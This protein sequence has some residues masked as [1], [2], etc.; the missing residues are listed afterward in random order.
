MSDSSISAE[1]V[2]E[3][4]GATA[5]HDGKPRVAVT[6]RE[7]DGTVLQELMDGTQIQTNPD[8]VRLTLK[9]DGSKI[10]SRPDGIVIEAKPNGSR[11]Q[12]FPDGCQIFTKSDGTVLQVNPDGTVFQTYSAD[13]DT[14]TQT[15]PDRSKV[16]IPADAMVYSEPY[17]PLQPVSSGEM[18][19]P[20]QRI[21]DALEIERLIDDMYAQK[22]NK[23]TRAPAS[24]KGGKTKSGS[25]KK[26]ASSEQKAARPADPAKSAP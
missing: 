7:D 9:P 19:T 22:S 20:R 4:P 8:G 18:D 25:K 26:K 24:K 15:R 11:I 10:Q 3:E 5:G 21:K 6:F 2:N 16:V 12:T 13:D 23:P 1:S 14:V 17:G